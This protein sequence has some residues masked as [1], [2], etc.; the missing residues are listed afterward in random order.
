MLTSRVG[1]H[2]SAFI[3]AGVLAA[4][5]VYY[6][7]QSQ[8]SEVLIGGRV[9]GPYPAAVTSTY[10]S[11]MSIQFNTRFSS[12]SR[13]CLS[14]S[15]KSSEGGEGLGIGE[16]G[17]LTVPLGGPGVYFSNNSGA[18]LEQL[19]VCTADPADLARF[20]DGSYQVRLQMSPGSSMKV[21]GV[22]AHAQR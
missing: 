11:A 1:S 22:S 8:A 16:S 13:I 20:K 4:I 21:S 17:K 15:L 19:L 9:Y 14:V 5:G 2:Y 10:P 18:K 7:A 12:L 6:V 3:L